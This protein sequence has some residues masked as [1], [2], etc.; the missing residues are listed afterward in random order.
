[1][2][3]YDYIAPSSNLDTVLKRVNKYAMQ[4]ESIIQ[5]CNTE[6]QSNDIVEIDTISEL[7]KL[8]ELK[9]KGIITEEEFVKL[10]AKLI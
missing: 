5:Q 9:E 7:A 1:M 8:A 3:I 6:N 4:I 10:K 2:P